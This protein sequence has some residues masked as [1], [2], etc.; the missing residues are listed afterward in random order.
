M[1][2]HLYPYL[3]SALSCFQLAVSFTFAVSVGR[4]YANVRHSVMSQRHGIK[5]GT[6]EEGFKALQVLTFL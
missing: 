1:S 2:L 4:N 5:G 6:S 3:R